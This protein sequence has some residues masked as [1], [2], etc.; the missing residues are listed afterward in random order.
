MGTGRYLG[1]NDLVD[2]ATLIPVLPYAYENSM[3][4]FKDLLTDLGD[5][6]IRSDMQARTLTTTTATT[7]TTTSTPAMNWVTKK[8]WYVDFNPGNASPGERLNVDPQLILGTLIFATNVPANTACS[9]GG[10]SWLYQLD[11]LEGTFVTTAA[12]AVAATKSNNA[13]VGFVVVKLPSGAIKIINTESTGAKG[14]VGVNVGSGGAGGK[15]VS[16]RERVN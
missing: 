5:L 12:N 9:V 14:T 13:T 6:R 8:G 7:R 3:Y 16:W 4:A 15:R 1:T 2:G 11:Y 10:D